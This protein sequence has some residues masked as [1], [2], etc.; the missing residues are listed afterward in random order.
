[1]GQR[2]AVIRQPKGDVDIAYVP[3]DEDDGEMQ[4]NESLICAAPDLLAACQALAH[5]LR[6]IHFTDGEY[7]L[8]EDAARQMVQFLERVV[9]KATEGR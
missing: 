4:D 8:T 2:R 5:D 7:R 6:A 1:V 9:S 3:V